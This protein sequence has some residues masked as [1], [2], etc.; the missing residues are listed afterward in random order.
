MI[1]KNNLATL[2]TVEKSGNAPA[3]VLANDVSM[4]GLGRGKKEEGVEVKT[5]LLHNRSTR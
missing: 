5:D 1:K 4:D 2:A 3:C